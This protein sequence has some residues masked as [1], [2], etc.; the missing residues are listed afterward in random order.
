MRQKEPFIAE[1]AP[2]TYAINEYGIAAE[3]LVI[4]AQRALLIDTGCGLL[5]LPAIVRRF[6]DKPLDVVLTHGHGD[7]VGGIGWFD[8]LYLHPA[9]FLMVEQVDWDQIRGYNRSLGGAGAFQVYDYDP[10]A[11]H[12]ME[13]LPELIPITE[14]YVF[15]LG[16]RSL[17]VIETPGHTAGSIVL[18]DDR[19]RILFSGDACN[20]NLGLFARPVSDALTYLKKLESLSGRFDQNWNGHIG[21]MG[22]PN[23]LAMP[24][25]VLPTCIHICQ[26]IVDGTAQPKVEDWFG[27]RQAKSVTEQGVRICYPLD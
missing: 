12:P 3:F 18:I 22:A 10:D 5:D 9:D 4:G 27:G 13:K 2:N 1:I 14:G 8:K 16:D 11:I 15:D 21:Y 20:V 23:C 6:T 24:P 19:Q 7:H 25:H 26:S 17:E